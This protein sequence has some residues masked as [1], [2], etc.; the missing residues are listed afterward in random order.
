[1]TNLVLHWHL[2]VVN[3]DR[4]VMDTTG[5]HNNGTVGGNPLT[6]PEPYRSPGRVVAPL[7][8]MWASCWAKVQYMW[9]NV[10]P[11]THW[12]FSHTCR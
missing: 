4:T 7:T 9:A 12:P 10:V 2:D 1:M 3:P 8:V 6:V 5:A 11:L